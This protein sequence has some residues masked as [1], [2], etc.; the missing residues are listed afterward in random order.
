MRKAL[1]R[2]TG[3]V[4]FCCDAWVGGGRWFHEGGLGTSA[5]YGCSN[6]SKLSAPEVFSTFAEKK[7]KTTPQKSDAVDH[8]P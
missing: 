2:C 4:A 8:Y 5:E 7:N 6:I 1:P 3:K